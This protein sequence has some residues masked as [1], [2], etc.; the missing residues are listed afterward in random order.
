M[1]RLQSIRKVLLFLLLSLFLTSFC[2]PEDMFTD[3][4]GD[5]LPSQTAEQKQSEQQKQTNK[6]QNSSNSNSLIELY[7]ASNSNSSLTESELA[8]MNPFE[9]LDL[10]EQKLNKADENFLVAIKSLQNSEA[11]LVRTRI[12]LNDSKATLKSLKQ[13][14]ISNKDD[15]SNLV[16]ELGALW[17]KVKS[18]NELISSLEKKSKKLTNARITATAFS[19]VG[20]GAI[21]LSNYVPDDTAKRILFWTGVGSASSGLVTLTVSFV[22]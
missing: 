7:N 8:S 13:A 3:V 12:E 11:D 10:L 5:F 2:S 15:T 17:E 14:L 22:F 18:L 6:E 1:C 19:C 9:L 20:V 21:V 16:S 4:T